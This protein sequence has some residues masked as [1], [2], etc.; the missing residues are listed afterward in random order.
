M[1]LLAVSDKDP[2]WRFQPSAPVF[3]SQRVPHRFSG[4]AGARRAAKRKKAKR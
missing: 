4:A 2:D 1:S 3:K